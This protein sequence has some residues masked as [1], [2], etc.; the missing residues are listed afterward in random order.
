MTT[1]LPER[2]QASRRRHV[3]DH[4]ITSARIRPGHDATVIDV[5]A[6]G[7]LV[8]TA[9]RLLP[10]SAVDVQ[11]ETP[12]RRATVR[13]RVLRCAVA[14][15][16]STAVCYR[17]AIGFDRHLPWFADNDGG[18]YPVHSHELRRG[19]PERARTTRTVL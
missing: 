5:S 3:D 6:G 11:L 12:D 16:G 7:A 2:R 8:E 14:S 17:G 9:H 15:V 18:G 4:N 13:G 1:S 19:G 10:G